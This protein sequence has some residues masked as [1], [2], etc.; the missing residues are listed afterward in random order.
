[1]IDCSALQGRS[2]NRGIGKFTESFIAN[3]INSPELKYEFLLS[4]YV[5]FRELDDVVDFLTPLTQIENIHVWEFDQTLSTDINHLIRESFIK[6]L[7]VD[8]VL[9]PDLFESRHHIPISINKFFQIPTSIVLHDLIPLEN[10]ELYLTNASEKMNYFEALKDFELADRIL[11]NS[12]YTLESAISN[13][14]NVSGKVHFIGGGPNAKFKTRLLNKKK[15][16]LSISGDDQRKNL[17]N[18]IE[19]WSNLP[20]EILDQ[21]VLKIVGNFPKARIEYFKSRFFKGLKYNDSLVFTGEISD[22]QLETELLQSIALIHPATAEGLGM[23]ILEAISVG[24]PAICSNTTSMQ[25]I[26]ALG[27]MFDPFDVENL[28]L[29]LKNTLLDPDLRERVRVSQEPI[30]LEYNWNQVVARTRTIFLEPSFYLGELEQFD[31]SRSSISGRKIVVVAP[32]VG[33]KTGIARY[34]DSL[35]PFLNKF[36]DVDFIPTESLSNLEESIEVLRKYDQVLVHL[37]NSP[38]HANA[39]RLVANYPTI[40][41]CHEVKFGKTLKDLHRGNLEWMTELEEL[42]PLE[43]ERLEIKSLDRI[44]NLALGVIVHSETAANFLQYCGI[45]RKKILLLPHPYLIDETF[46]IANTKP[47]KALSEVTTAG[48]VT[49]NKGG[50]LLIESIALYNSQNKDKLRLKMLGEAGPDYRDQ[51]YSLAKEK[52]IS[53]NISGYL[54]D[55][56]Y[57]E[58]IAKAQIAIQIRNLDSGESSGVVS[59]LIFFGV[60]TIVNDIGA[61]SSYSSDVLRRIMN[62]PSPMEIAKAIEDLQ[63]QKTRTV[64]SGKS[65]VYAREKCSPE[66]SARTLLEFMNSRFERDLLEN[67]RKFADFFAAKEISKFAEIC[68]NL[69]KQN[70]FFGYRKIV[71]SDVTNLQSTQYMSGIQRATTEIHK[72]IVKVFPTERYI[73]GGINLN[74]SQNTKLSSNFEISNDFFVT[75]SFMTLENVDAILLL[76]LNFDFYKANEYK[77]LRE[78]NIPIITNLYDVL[79]VSHPEWFPPLAA[80]KFF[81]PWLTNV[82]KV[83]SD[84]IVNSESTLKDLKSLDCFS[85]YSGLIHVAPLDVSGDL[86][87]KSLKRV[88]G[89]TLIVGTIEPRK[90][91][92]DVLNAFDNLR[93]QHPELTLHIAGR[94]GWMVESL[95]DRIRHHPMLN[96]SLFWYSDCSDTELK[97]LYAE[98]EITIIASKGEGFGLPLI[99]ASRNGSCVIARDI[100]VFREIG[101]DYANFFATDSSN[102]SEIWHKVLTGELKNKPRGLNAPS[103]G[104]FEYALL[105]ESILNRR[106]K[107]F[108]RK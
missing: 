94:Q 42:V 90:G 7:A 84:I 1:M 65:K 96:R 76:D 72:E 34:T 45:A 64:L 17:S 85:S 26:G 21:Y 38:H 86:I 58:A 30:L 80:E 46:V 28:S 27:A 57:L 92:E 10:P 12:R 102:L 2:W 75:N 95:V 44:L 62:S 73:L 35:L 71:A 78:R 29:V 53:L 98:S 106:L 77:S 89:Q 41:L 97:T 13:F 99:E 61:F 107:T 16:I 105:L 70:S 56:E 63:D 3:L 49:P 69:E 14:G 5:G 31:D 67:G 108:H 25:E 54:E 37:G 33:A 23:P 20:S 48:F 68:K 51:L 43:D 79:P 22:F 9:I 19:A 83:S 36:A 91:H 50:E 103:N 24:V 60:P 100:P 66:N 74:S 81:I 15:Q 93:N 82:L 52:N 104:Y 8:A 55:E 88:K 59:D 18:L 11:C 87:L 4:N 6:S 47:V 39:F 101:S 40:I 32:S